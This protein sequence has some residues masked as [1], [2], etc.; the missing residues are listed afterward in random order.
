MIPV[1]VNRSHRK[2]ESA[3]DEVEELRKV[4]GR[5]KALDTQTRLAVAAGVRL[6]N[7]DFLTRF[8]GTRSLHEVPVD[9]QKRFLAELVDLEFGLR[10]G[11]IGM[12]IGVGLYRIWLTDLFAGDRE[13]ADRHDVPIMVHISTQPPDISYVVSMLKEGDVLE[14]I[15]KK[16]IAKKLSEAKKD[17]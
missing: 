9:A 6:A 10:G 16:E 2:K 12:A 3:R 8:S 7:A 1:F 15:S 14:A 4:L 11:D 5:L 17:G 13:V